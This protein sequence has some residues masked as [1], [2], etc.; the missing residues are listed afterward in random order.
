[1]FGDLILI[2]PDE[3]FTGQSLSCGA[4]GLQPGHPLPQLHPGDPHHVQDAVS[5][6]LIL[7]FLVS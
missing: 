4:P 3:L 5:Q 2:V 7:N 6:T 1:M